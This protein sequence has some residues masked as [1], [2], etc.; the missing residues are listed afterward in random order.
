MVQ[1]T[2]SAVDVKQ[3]SRIV[4]STRFGSQLLAVKNA[5]AA[6]GPE[7]PKVLEPMIPSTGSLCI[8]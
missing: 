4:I 5:V 8:L 2:A 1:Q 3:G 6:G 7:S